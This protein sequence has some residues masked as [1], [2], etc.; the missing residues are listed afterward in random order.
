M[1]SASAYQRAAFFHRVM[2]SQLIRF[3]APKG[4]VQSNST[5]VPA[6]LR[7]FRA[8][9]Q[10]S[11]SYLLQM[12]SPAKHISLGWSWVQPM[13]RSEDTLIPKS[14]L[15]PAGFNLILFLFPKASKNTH[16]T[17]SS[18]DTVEP[19]SDKKETA[20]NQRGSGSEQRGGVWEKLRNRLQEWGVF[21]EEGVDGSGAGQQI[22]L[23][24]PVSV[25]TAFVLRSARVQTAALWSA[26]AGSHL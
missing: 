5:A 22:V 18:A 6:H 7:V 15:D 25:K 12:S 14:S 3:A 21:L 11:V 8:V 1:G 13:I 16:T 9:F 20:Q 10:W 17:S 26:A 4:F 23:S 2:L 24:R 19:Q